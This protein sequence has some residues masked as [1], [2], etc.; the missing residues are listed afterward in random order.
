MLI[1]APYFFLSLHHPPP[2]PDPPDPDP[3]PDLFIPIFNSTSFS[4][5]EAYYARVA[6]EEARAAALSKR[7][8]RDCPSPFGYPSALLILSC[9]MWNMSYIGMILKGLGYTWQTFLA[10]TYFRLF[11]WLWSSLSLFTW[12]RRKPA[13][14]NPTKSNRKKLLLLALLIGVRKVQGLAHIGSVSES[15]LRRRLRR[16]T[17]GR[18]TD[19]KLLMSRLKADDQASVLQALQSLPD[20]LLDP[21]DLKCSIFDTGASFHA[22]GFESDFVPGSLKILPTPIKLDGIAGSLTAT[23]EGTL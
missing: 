7:N 6:E 14:P 20:T 4:Q 13:A 2:L 11:H 18:G 1:G 3:R 15:R 19:A 23:K 16:A 5:M 17:R 8:S 10:A 12:F 9:V 22:T 21:G